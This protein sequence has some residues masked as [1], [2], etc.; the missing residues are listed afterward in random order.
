MTN[1]R[2]GLIGFGSWAR[3][4]YVPALISD[5][6]IEIV[7][8]A[9]RT[10]QTHLAAREILGTGFQSY[11]DYNTL[12]ERDDIDAVMIGMPSDSGTDTAQATINAD[13]HVFFE[14]PLED[15]PLTEKLL[16][17]AAKSD[18]VFHA[19]L[20]LRYLPCVDTLL[21]ITEL[22]DFGTVQFIHVSLENDWAHHWD[23]DEAELTRMVTGLSTWYIDP[24]DL[25]V[26]HAAQ[27]VQIVGAEHQVGHARLSFK[28]GVEGQWQFNLRST[29]EFSVKMKVT[30]EH[31]EIQ[32]DLLSGECHWNIGS[33]LNSGTSSCLQ[34]VL[35]FVGMQE[36]VRAFLAAIRGEKPTQSGPGVYS[37]IHNTIKALGK[38]Q[39]SNTETTVE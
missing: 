5:Q 8:V 21:K 7:A 22:Q 34:P 30:G 38:S 16:D 10:D 28:D 13:K 6:D 19:D 25:L 12:L 33:S 14:P 9:A 36:S 18:R 17:Q 4:A 1:I 27:T 39:T 32:A 11:T 35:G 24:I 3:K 37:R 23:L 20:E 31:G 2:I 15:S 26:G 29:N